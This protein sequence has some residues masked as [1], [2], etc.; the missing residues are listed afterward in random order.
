MLWLASS[1][2]AVRSTLSGVVRS[3]PSRLKRAA[4]QSSPLWTSRRWM[5]SSALPTVKPRRPH[6]NLEPLATFGQTSLHAPAAKQDRD[7]A[8]DAHPEPLALLEPW[9]VLEGFSFRG[10]R[11]APLGNALLAHPGLPALFLILGAVEAPIASV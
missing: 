10:L 11:S 6:Q 1:E 5:R 2:S 9:A 4:M 3:V 8:L 7:A